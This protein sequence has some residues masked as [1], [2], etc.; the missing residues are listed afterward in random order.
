MKRRGANTVA[1]A[2]VD[3]VVSAARSRSISA[4]T[5]TGEVTTRRAP[6]PENELYA[7]QSPTTATISTSVRAGR[8]AE[9]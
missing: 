4:A 2:V 9:Q 6:P 5:A 8:T 7:T 1:V 3:A